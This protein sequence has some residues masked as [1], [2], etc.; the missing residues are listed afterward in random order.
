MLRNVLHPS[1]S[2]D[3]AMPVQDAEAGDREHGRRT[4]DDV[5]LRGH[6]GE[7]AASCLV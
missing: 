3:Q 6:L 4:Y 2:F 7:S 1:R 5:P